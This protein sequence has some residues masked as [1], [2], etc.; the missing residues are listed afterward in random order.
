MDW[1]LNDAGPRH[2]RVEVSMS[3]ANKKNK[4]NSVFQKEWNDKKN[5][6]RINHVCESKKSA[7]VIAHTCAANANAKTQK[8]KQ[9]PK[10]LHQNFRNNFSKGC[11]LRIVTPDFPCSLPEKHFTFTADFIFSKVIF[12]T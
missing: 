9:R 4:K 11:L 6:T 7:E 2:A 5:Y 10:Y 1:L 12:L 8:Q 3:N